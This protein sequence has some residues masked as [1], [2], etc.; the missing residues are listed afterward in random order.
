MLWVTVSDFR[1]FFVVLGNFSKIAAKIS[2]SFPPSLHQAKSYFRR[3]YFHKYVVCKRCHRIYLFKECIQGPRGLPTSKLCSFQEFSLHP[4][5][6]MQKAC[7]T[8]LLKNV[9]LASGR[10]CLME[11]MERS[12][13]TPDFYKHC[14]VW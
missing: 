4:Q 3:L 7:E 5:K 9:E 1:K 11:S 8:V 2:D 13:L 12:L 14:E 6:R 10:R